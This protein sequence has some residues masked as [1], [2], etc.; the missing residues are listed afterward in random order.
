MTETILDVKNLS[1]DYKIGKKEFNVAKDISFSLEK[2]KT[3]GIVGESGCGKSVMTSS[4]IGLLPKGVGRIK[5]GS[6]NF[7]GQELV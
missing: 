2:G 4:I 6:I 7:E 1:V 3:L 5:K